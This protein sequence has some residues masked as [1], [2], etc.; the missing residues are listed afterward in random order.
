GG[1]VWSP[2]GTRI[3]FA[4]QVWPGLADDAAQKARADEREKSGV[5]A[6]IFDGLLFRHWNAFNEGRRSQLFVVNLAD[7]KTVQIT[8]E[9]RDAPPFSLGGPPDY[10]WGADG[11]TIWYTRGAKPEVEAWSTN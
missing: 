5:R 10:S 4:S 8:R 2:D 1:P 9:N 3:L 6:M 7:G 11:S